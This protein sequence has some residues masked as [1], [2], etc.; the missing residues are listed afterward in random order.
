[1]YNNYNTRCI[2]AIAVLFEKER[3]MNMTCV[4]PGISISIVV[5]YISKIYLYLWG[6]H[7]CIE[8][9]NNVLLGND[10]SSLPSE[11]QPSGFRH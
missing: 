6:I 4:N 3:H 8:N 1:M 7:Y 10:V 11:Q 5:F 9:K 2:I